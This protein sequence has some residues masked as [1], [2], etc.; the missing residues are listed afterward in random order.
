M[1]PPA[2]NQAWIEVIGDLVDVDVIEVFHAMM[3]R[4][5]LITSLGSMVSSILNTPRSGPGHERSET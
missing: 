2:D 4:P 1:G 3:L 5:S